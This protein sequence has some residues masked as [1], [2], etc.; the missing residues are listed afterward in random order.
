MGSSV[1]VSRFVTTMVSI[2]IGLTFLF[3]FGNVLALAL[4]IGVPVYV[5]PAVDLTVLGLLVGT[6]RCRVRRT[7]CCGRLGAQMVS[8]ENLVKWNLPSRRQ[9]RRKLAH[10]GAQPELGSICCAT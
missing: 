9:A 7:K 8:I 5:A 1:S 4:R 10:G 6:W 3:G 2:V